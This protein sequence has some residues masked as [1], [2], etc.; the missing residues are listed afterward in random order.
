MPFRFRHGVLLLVALL[1]LF[2]AVNVRAQA[3]TTAVFLYDGKL[4]DQVAL[5][6]LVRKTVEPH[7]AKATVRTMHAGR[8][9]A[10]PFLK[11]HSL[12][13]KNAPVLLLMDGPGER[14][15]IVRKVYIDPA[16][17][18]RQT[19]RL[20]L[21]VLKLPQV[22]NAPPA[23]GPLVTIL[24]DGGEAEK[25]LLVT[26]AGQQSLVAESRLL[27]A[28]GVVIYRLRLPDE[29]RYADLTAE[30]AGNFAVDWAASPRGPWVPL[31]DGF[32]YFGAASESITRRVSPVANLDQ[33]LDKSTGE[34]YL[35]V[36][37]NGRG[38]NQAYLG[39]LEVIARSA[40]IESGESQWLLEA[41]RLRD[42]ALA[43]IVPD[44]Q[45]HRPLGGTLTKDLTLLA[46][47]SP[48]LLSGDLMVG[49][50]STLTIEPGVTVRVAP[51]TVI[52]VRG[53]LV[54][55][56]TVKDPIRFLPAK[57]D[58]AGSWKGIFFSPLPNRPSGTESELSFCRIEAAGNLDLDQ[59]AGEISYC[60]LENCVLGATLRH[61]GKGRVHHNRFLKCRRGVVVDGGGG[62]VTENEL[63]ECQQAVNVVSL[64][65]ENP[66]R[67]E[68]NSV[69]NSRVAAVTYLKIPGQERPAL[70]LPN[71]FWGD[72]PAARLI[73]GG[74]DAAAVVLDPKLEAAPAGVGPGWQ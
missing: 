55:K 45:R 7:A 22:V 72:T 27:D 46:A 50:T 47:D 1:S 3:Q 68:R 40:T 67:F 69:V 53:Q 73:G 62:E 34:L 61:G 58:P 4:P 64:D 57:D 49:P 74:D 42:E 39:R 37:T 31:M 43:R 30:L 38:R 5:E 52:R 54:A 20:V 11:R 13:R 33:V 71:N 65:A 70:A 26:R 35:R 21:S 17:D 18:E 19:V 24:A 25:K 29:L 36:R 63:T 12:T 16:R 44:V 51:G 9:E 56:G 66:L 14:A 23:P 10:A 28:T 60:I 48:Y 59:F 15:K 6:A 32:K 41:I 2:A 8:A